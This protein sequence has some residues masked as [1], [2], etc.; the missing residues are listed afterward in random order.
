MKQTTY[1]CD[2]C[3]TTK[4][5]TNHWFSLLDSGIGDLPSLVIYQSLVDE[6]EVLHV[7]GTE[8]LLK[9][10]TKLLCKS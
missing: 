5:E 3:G 9:R 2:E 10:I 4:K 6:D 7:C 1:T 8:C